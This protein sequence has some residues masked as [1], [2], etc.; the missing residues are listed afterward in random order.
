MFIFFLI[1]FLVS[2]GAGILLSATTLYLQKDMKARLGRNDLSCFLGIS[3][4]VF[5]WTVLLNSYWTN[6]QR[7]APFGDVGMYPLEAKPLFLIF[8]YMFLIGLTPITALPALM[9][10]G[11]GRKWLTFDSMWTTCWRIILMEISFR[12]FGVWHIV[13]GPTYPLIQKR[14]SKSISDSKHPQQCID[15]SISN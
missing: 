13:P 3:L 9:L 14:R 11:P 12:R 1:F 4:G 8:L 10:Y 7:A 2:I 5:I 15:T 6:F